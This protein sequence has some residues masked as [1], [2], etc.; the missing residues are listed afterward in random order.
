M[1]G[2]CTRTSTMTPRTKRGESIAVCINQCLPDPLMHWLD[3]PQLCQRQTTA[4]Q[5]M[6]GGEAA[7]QLCGE[8][9]SLAQRRKTAALAPKMENRTDARALCVLFSSCGWTGGRRV[10]SSRREI[11]CSGWGSMRPC[12]HELLMA[13]VQVLCASRRRWRR[14]RT[15][16]QRG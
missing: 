4:S 2:A 16:R 14:K 13:Q 15:V 7:D 5:S 12:G 8:P 6:Y 3:G 10:A 9:L 11:N 1:A